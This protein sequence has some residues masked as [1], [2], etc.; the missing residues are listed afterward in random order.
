[1]SGQTKTE[2]DQRF[3]S[4]RHIPF[5]TEQLDAMKAMYLAGNGVT[6]ISDKYGIAPSTVRNRLS[7]M[8]VEARPRGRTRVMSDEVHERVKVL[9]Q[10]GCDWMEVQELLGV[11]W[12]TASADVRHRA[13]LDRQ[14]RK[15]DLEQ[16]ESLKA[17][18]KKAEADLSSMRG[19]LQALGKRAA[20]ATRGLQSVQRALSW[21][22][23]NRQIS[24]DGMPGWLLYRLKRLIQ[25][26]DKP[27]S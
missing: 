21:I 9:R 13:A 15:A 22:M 20:D 14:A 16:I 25:F 26:E 19:S 1:M 4:D 3:G 18:L 10:A 8:G 24:L 11:R 17:A 6:A 27:L 7:S 2:F 12:E 5:T 23:H